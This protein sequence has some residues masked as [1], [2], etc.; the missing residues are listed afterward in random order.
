MQING[1]NLSLA[2]ITRIYQNNDGTVQK[3]TFHTDDPDFDAYVAERNEVLKEWKEKFSTEDPDGIPKNF[4]MSG[5][6]SDGTSGS[7]VSEKISKVF[8]QYY[9]GGADEKEIETTLRDIVADF[10]TSYVNQGFDPDTFMPRLLEDV[11]VSARLY[12]ISSVDLKS[13]IEG[14]T[15]AA[16]Y[17][18]SNV[19]SRDFIYY[20]A[21]YYYQSEAMKD[22]TIEIMQKIAR[23]YGVSNAEFPREYEDGDIRKG[24]YGSYN[25]IANEYLRHEFMVGNMVDETMAP[26]KDFG[27]FYKGNDSGTNNYQGIPSTHGVPGSTFDGILH[28]WYGD[29][30]YTG[31]VPVRQDATQFPISINMYDTI[32]ENRSD[33]PEEIVPMLKNF[34]FFTVYLSGRYTDAHPRKF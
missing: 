12:N 11:Y 17:N 30:S 22:T 33:I 24:I 27:F 18:G 26:P 13:H 8:K 23:E 16:R 19:N 34:D 32:A 28:V 10:R 1:I 4:L 15:L 2:S 21:K 3:K 9:A 31:R 20:D 6:S 25:T 29:W 5:I 14:R 7:R